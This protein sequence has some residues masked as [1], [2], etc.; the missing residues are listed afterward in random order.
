MR[1]KPFHSPSCLV[2]STLASRVVT[3][4]EFEVLG[5]IVVAYPINVMNSLIRLERAAND[6]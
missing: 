5:T 3:P 2:V 6:L 1:S 4:P